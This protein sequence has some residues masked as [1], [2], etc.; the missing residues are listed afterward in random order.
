MY[1]VHVQTIKDNNIINDTTSLM[2]R[3]Y[4]KKYNLKIIVHFRVPSGRKLQ[5]HSTGLSH[6]NYWFYR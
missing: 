3:Y 6:I 4:D 5:L 1:I 2:Y